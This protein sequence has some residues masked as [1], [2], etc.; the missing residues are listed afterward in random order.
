MQAFKDSVPL[1]ADLKNDALRD[2]H[3]QKLMESTKKNFDMNPETF[4]LE[5]LFA[6]ELHNFAD[7][8]SEIV[9]SATKELSIEK[10]LVEVT[11]TWSAMKFAVHRYTKGAQERGYI[12]GAVDDINTILDDNAMNL[13]SMSASSFVGP[14][15]ENVQRWE[16]R[17]SHI[18]E[19]VDV[20]MVVQR[21]WMYLESIFIGG[22]IRSQLPEEAK[23]FD[24]IDK[25]F[26]KIMTDTHQ[27]TNVLQACHVDGRLEDLESLAGGLERCQKSL[28]DYLDS[29]RNAFPRFFFISDDELLSILGSAEATCVQEHMIK[30]FDNIASLKFGAG[31]SQESIAL[32]MVSSEGEE[33]E[34]R[35]PVVAEGRVE[36]WMT[37]VLNEMRRTNRLITKES[38]FTYCADDR[39]RVQWMGLYQGMVVLAS[40]Q[41]WW[42]W[43]VE[44]VF[45][46]VKKGDKM[47][48]KVYSKK[49]HG[50]IDELV[51]QVRSPLSKND[52]KKF[53]T[54]LIIDVHNRD[55]IDMFVRDSI[56]D[57]REFEWECQLRFY[58]E[59]K[60]DELFIRQCTGRFGYGYEYMGLNGRLVITPLTDRIYLTLTQALSMR[61][62]GAP[63]GP[64]GT[65]KTETVKDL[66]KALGLLCVVTNC[67]E[68]MDFKAVGKIFSGLA[69][70]GAWGC[71]DEFNRIDISVLSVISSQI[72]TIQNALLNGFKRFQVTVDASALLIVFIFFF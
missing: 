39:T 47:A 50:Q 22:D 56:M 3:W 26:K 15:L 53:N 35:S 5:N 7:V 62:G 65:G 57:A 18:S 20:W 42:T 2:R 30:M 29:K 17:L 1:F 19:V 31:S 11:D 14:F 25:T 51:V 32:G 36:D 54:V 12:L 28:N 40:N 61:L 66:A 41:V 71:F 55:I 52:R 58:W 44:D 34:F 21:K 48:M 9:T 67:G 33:M 63:A 64:A 46:K 59:R 10:G 45:R 4:T 37:N 27:K 38:I 68:G 16:K 23:K 69:Q 8:I 13:Q 72:K 24:G 43:E 60:G 6:M 49:L 70:C